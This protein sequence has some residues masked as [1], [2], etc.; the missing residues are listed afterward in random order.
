MALAGE[1]NSATIPA[2]FTTPGSVPLTAPAYSAAGHEVALSLNFA[3]QTGCNLTVVNVTG[4]DFIEGR[5]SNLG[6]GQ[7]VALQHDGLVYKF[8]A[9]YYGGSGNDLVLHWAAQEMAVWGANSDGQLGTGDTETATAPVGTAPPVSALLGR[10]VTAIAS[11]KN[12]QLALCSDGTLAAWGYNTDGQIGN[13][14]SRSSENPL[15]VDRTGVLLGKA[16]ISIAARSDHN[17]VLCSDGTL[18]SW[19]ANWRGQLGRL[20]NPQAPSDAPGLVDQSGVLA[21]KTVV[22]ISVG[23]SHCLVLCSDGTLVAWGTGPLGNGP[24]PYSQQFSNVPVQVDQSGVLAGKTV[25]SISAGDGISLAVCSDGTLAAWGINSYG[26][27]GNGQAGFGLVSHIPVLVRQDGVLAGKQVVAAAAGGYHALALCSDGTLAA[28]GYNSHGPLGTG[29][30]NGSSVP[31]AVDQTGFLAGRQVVSL[32]AGL[33]N[34]LAI[35]ADGS[36]AEWGDGLKTPMSVDRGI[37]QGKAVISVTSGGGR[38]LALCSDGTLA[39]WEAWRGVPVSID[40]EPPALFGKTVVSLT[41]SDHSLALCADGTLAAWG[42]GYEGQLGLGVG[43]GSQSRAIR[44]DQKGVLAGKAVVAVAAGARHSLALCADGTIAAWGANSRGQLGDGSFTDRMLPVAVNQAGSLAG[45][46]VVALEAGFDFSLALCS[47]GTVFT[48]GH[49]AEGQ[50]GDGTVSNRNTPVAVD[51]SGVLAGKSVVRI[52]SKYTHS[53]A[54]CNDGTLVTWGSGIGGLPGIPATLVPVLVDQSTVLAG[55][56]IISIKTFRE[57]SLAL[58]SDGTLAAWGRNAEGQFGNGNTTSSL[59]PVLVDRSGVLAG[60]TVVEIATG[61]SHSV[62]ICSDATLVAWGNNA[63]GQLGIGNRLDPVPGSVPVAVD[64]AGILAGKAVTSLG[65]G[66]YH[67]LAIAA[68]SPLPLKNIATSAGP[69]P[70][71]PTINSYSLSVAH[72]ADTITITPTY[73]SPASGVTVQGLPVASDVASSP[74]PLAVGTNLV[75][76]QV[77]GSNELVTNYQIRVIRRT[78]SSDSTLSALTIDQGA[79]SPA[80]SPQSLLYDVEFPNPVSTVQVAPIASNEKATILVNDIPPAVSGAGAAVPLAVGSNQIRIRITAEDG[81]H[82]SIYT[83]RINRRPPDPDLAALVTSAGALTPKFSPS[84]T[85]YKMQVSNGS[86][87]MRITPTCSD[88]TAIL[89]VNGT[90]VAS[91]V[92]SGLIPLKVGGNTVSVSVGDPGGFA[93]K[94]YTLQ[95]TR[96]NPPDAILSGLSVVGAGL[97]PAFKPEVSAYTAKVANS[98][99]TAKIKAV[100]SNRVASITVD[101]VRFTSG[102]ASKSV[103]LAVGQNIILVKA[104]GKDGTTKTYK[105]TVTRASARSSPAT[106]AQLFPGASSQTKRPVVSR[107]SSGSLSYLQIT[108]EKGPDGNRP[109]VEVS[110]N[111]MDWF[112]GEKHTEVLMEN[113]RFVVVRDKTPTSP[114]AKRHIRLKP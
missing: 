6:Q 1:A 66:N 74:I 71:E 43:Y 37:L 35:C 81:D 38:N 22:K 80:F 33:Y 12:H 41:G 24:T 69:I 90:S 23:D 46:N 9:N 62:A 49:N 98:T 52:A 21:G 14:T 40:P 99:L 17:L 34:S 58:C 30:D 86:T 84:V 15:P 91:G 93:V 3:P 82:Y 16:I 68:I 36:L 19:G 112:S 44:I 113:G 76:V 114:S 53:I 108:A 55:K 61:W 11:G 57:G 85:S 29:S 10:N 73:T 107:M 60:K 18:V 78:E 63:A 5:F 54:L 94:T 88:T 32:V 83:L 4:L 105:I 8:A 48:W 100:A 65:L 109:V 89:K 75:T 50:L 106:L 47:D 45:K 51:R 111:L 96:A 95:I 56:T 42:D 28:W 7:E 2:S 102:A 70:F 77:T 110:S 104:T 26:Q 39:I 79:L 101:G 13:G 25:V 59:L 72:E 27:L 92:E 97:S 87:S 103:R 20:T 67:N 31:A 64:R